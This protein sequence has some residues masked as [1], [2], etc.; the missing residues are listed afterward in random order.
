MQKPNYDFVGFS[1]SPTGSGTPETVASPATNWNNLLLAAI[2][3][4]TTIGTGGIASATTIQPLSQTSGV[5][6]R[7]CDGSRNR[8]PN[9]SLLLPQEQ[10]NAI[11]RYL[12]LNISD[13]AVTLR[14]ARPTVYA[15]LRGE[16]EPHDSNLARIQKLYSFGLVWRALSDD[17]VG[18]FLKTPNRDG[19]TLLNELSEEMLDEPRIRNTFEQI[20]A[21]MS[22]ASKRQSIAVIARS[23]GL[24]P[25]SRGIQKWSDDTLLSD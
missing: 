12:S 10:I 5:I 9:E 6:V 18:P 16:A 14:V 8:L 2:L 24:T 15:W 13:L 21:S 1:S 3:G 23:R 22:S 7:Y 19:S 20:R 4:L 11:R 25:V 17:P